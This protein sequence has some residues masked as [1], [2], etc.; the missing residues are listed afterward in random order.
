MLICIAGKNNIAIDIAEIIVQLPR[1]QSKE[2]QFAGIPNYSDKGV[3]SFQ[4]SYRKWLADHCI[5]I[6]TLESIYGEDDLLFL[7]L[8]FDKIIK[9][10]LF[11]SC[12]LYNIHF[13]LL[14]KYRGMY[15][16][17][18]PLLFSETIT[19]VTLH[20]IDKGIDTGDIIEQYSFSILPTDNCRDLYHKY[21][22]HGSCLVRKNLNNMLEDK[23]STIPQNYENASYF[24]K[25][26]INYKNISIDLYQCACNIRNQIR[27]FNFREYQL[28][29]IN[30]ESVI[31]CAITQN[32]SFQR[33]G[34][35]H[36]INDDGIYVST[37]DYDCMLYYDRFGQLLEACKQGDL[38][39]VQKI[40][41]VRRHLFEKNEHGWTAL[42]V[43]IYNGH[44]N[45][46]KWL[47][48]QGSDAFAV[49]NHGTNMLMYSKELWVRT[50]NAS[51]FELFL[52][53]GLNTYQR[54]FQGKSLVDYC[55]ADG[56]FEIGDY[57]IPPPNRTFGAGFA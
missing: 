30:G 5:S 12:R 40:C 44:C 36:F 52:K 4:R 33:P 46:V 53:L 27:A 51:L 16:S 34:Y 14:P 20:R 15:T 55:H 32:H 10:E 41:I 54:D 35:I 22:K 47:L 29:Q 57:K 6:I 18:L 56:I 19:G 50:R 11:R 21:I 49:N 43:A 38:F 17:T 48:S 1:V 37:I 13:S 8:E 39:T 42:M 23:I 26:A 25:S 31:D 28:P 24:S 3:D 2:W 45:I 9:P 7:S